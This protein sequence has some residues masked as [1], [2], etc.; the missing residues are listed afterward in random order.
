M[1]TSKKPVG[2]ILMD[3]NAVAGIGNIYRADSFQGRRPPLNAISCC[4][5]A[6]GLVAKR[7]HVVCVIS[8]CLDNATDYGESIAWAAYTNFLQAAHLWLKR[9]L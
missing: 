9:S 2:G 4:M 6:H 7:F 5:I 3:Q 8:I 1:R